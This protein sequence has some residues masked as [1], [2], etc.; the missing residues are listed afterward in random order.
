M[1]TAYSPNIIY[2]GL[3]LCLDAGNKKSYSGNGVTWNDLSGNNSS[4]SLINGPTFNSGSGGSI[5][6]DGTNDYVTLKSDII[7]SNNDLTVSF[8]S[9]SNSFSN[10]NTLLGNY[11]SNGHLQIRYDTSGRIDVVK[12]YIAQIGPFTAHTESIN[13]ISNIVVTKASSTY[14]LYV[15]GV[16]KSQLTSALTFN[17]GFPALG[18]NYDVA[19]SKTV[20]LMNGNIYSFLYYNRALSVQEVQQNF[21][22]NRK[23]FGV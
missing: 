14:S 4:G 6:F 3:V 20:E 18:V 10:S 8:W 22:A 23:R 2:K 13:I 19:N 12:S 11:S 16:Y 21:V 9:K 7:N 15:N 5:V 1:T 17:T